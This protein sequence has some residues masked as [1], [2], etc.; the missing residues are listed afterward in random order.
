M[1]KT[2]FILSQDHINLLKNMNVS[3]NGDEY[4]APTI[5]PKRPYGNSNVENDICRLLGW[6]ESRYEFKKASWLHLE[7]ACALQIALVY[8]GQPLLPGVYKQTKEYDYLSWKR[9]DADE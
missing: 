9:V 2:E 7:M 4:G 5:D 1:N 3:W 6:V 8:V